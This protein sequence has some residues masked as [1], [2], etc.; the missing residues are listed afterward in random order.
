MHLKAAEF[1]VES[2]LVSV[3]TL[4]M[5][6]KGSNITKQQALLG[7]KLSISQIN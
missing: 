4:I 3:P 7:N 2:H 6:Y 5:Y 1:V